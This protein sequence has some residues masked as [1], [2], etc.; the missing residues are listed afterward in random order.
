ME[1]PT[2][3]E[4]LT[5][6][7]WS[8]AYVRFAIFGLLILGGTLVMFLLD[9]QQLWTYVAWVILGSIFGGFLMT[10]SLARAFGRGYRCT[11]C[12]HVFEVSARTF[13]LSPSHGA[14]LGLS[15]KRLM[16]PRCRT[17]SFK[18]WLRKAMNLELKPLI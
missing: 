8:I 9:V 15:K 2:Q 5:A 16:C 3:F 10:V 7:D 18:I 6:R 12:G 13:V 4:E 14:R 1:S 17:R 11:G